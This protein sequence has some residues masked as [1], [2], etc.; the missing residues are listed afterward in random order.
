M[1]RSHAQAD[2]AEFIHGSTGTAKTKE[3]SKTLETIKIVE[4]IV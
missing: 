2:R 3:N 4:A 1:Q